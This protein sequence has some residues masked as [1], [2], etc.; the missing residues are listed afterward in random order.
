MI[1]HVLLLQLPRA[2]SSREDSGLH[3]DTKRGGGGGGADAR[4]SSQK[5]TSLV[6]LEHV[7]QVSK[8]L[9]TRKDGEKA[10]G[11]SLGVYA[12]YKLLQLHQMISNRHDECGSSLVCFS[13]CLL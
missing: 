2:R 4:Q 1:E 9:D 13:S 12:A 10:R 5:E 7:R 8:H 11:A 3:V 6:C